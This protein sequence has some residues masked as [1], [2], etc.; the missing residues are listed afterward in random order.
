[1]HI[2]L[3][4]LWTGKVDPWGANQIDEKL[5]LGNLFDAA[6]VDELKKRGV[7]RVVT[8]ILGVPALHPSHF[9]YKLVPVL[10][11]PR[12]D[13]YV[14]L[15]DA[16]DFIENAIHQQ[17]ATVLVHCR[18]GISRSG[19]VVTAYIMKKY[20]MDPEQALEY[21]RK[22]RP[23]VLPNAGFRQQLERFHRDL[24]QQRQQQQVTREEKK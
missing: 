10:D 1:M 13:L 24:Q 22:R 11:V 18:Q 23:I 8:V 5:F 9:E 4:Q 14:H 15:H 3:R 7:S 6:N 17:N 19:S 12:E 21:V 20:G 2:R 16:V